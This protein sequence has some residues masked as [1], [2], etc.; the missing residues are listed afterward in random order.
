MISKSKLKIRAERK[1]NPEVAETVLAAKKLAAWNGIGKMVSGSTR[2]YSSVNLSDIDK[3]TSAGDTV[4]IP[5]KVLGS[6]QL[7]KK[8]RICALGFSDSAREKL[9]KHKGEIVTILEEIHK[10]PKAEGLK[11]IR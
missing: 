3:Q 7:S 6:G 11:V 1:T 10:N 5:G 8:V 9:G 4:I 2:R